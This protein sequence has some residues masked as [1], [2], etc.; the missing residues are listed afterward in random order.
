M[1]KKVSADL[2]KLALGERHKKDSFFTEV[3]NGPSYGANELLIMDAIAFKKSWANPCITGYEVKISRGDFLSDEKWRGY[4]QYCNRFS[5]VCPKDMIELEELPDYVGLVYYDTEK[6]SLYTRRKATFRDIDPPVGMMQYLIMRWGRQRHPFFN[7]KVEYFEKLREGKAS[8]KR[9]GS[10][11]AKSTQKYIYE[12]ED[13]VG[14]L[15][16]EL[17]HSSNSRFIKNL[18]EI[19][20]GYNDGKYM[21]EYKILDIVKKV[22]ETKMPPEAGQSVLNIQKDLD[23]LKSLFFISESTDDSKD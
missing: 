17:E 8:K 18:R 2:I 11:V 20:I 6:G 10:Y 3:K 7:N 5:F 12:L 13:R 14:E 21:P 4:L 23:Q 22:L 1:T 15:E 9:L 19:I 16:R